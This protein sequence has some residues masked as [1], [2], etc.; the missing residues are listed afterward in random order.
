MPREVLPGAAV[1]VAVLVIAYP[2]AHT[3]EQKT[4]FFLAAILF[5][6][7]AW[8]PLIVWG[9]QARRA[10][11]RRSLQLDQLWTE[12]R[13]AR[14]RAYW[15]TATA[16][17]VAALVLDAIPHPTYDTTCLYETKPATWPLQQRVDAA[18]W[19]KE[20]LEVHADDRP[21]QAVEIRRLR[22]DLLKE[23]P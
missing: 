22:G 3:A 5:N 6:I 17:D 19:C 18:D 20:W 1:I 2:A 12:L 4:Y 16:K 21:T 9:V 13:H 11:R 8:V 14:D 7:F 10:N 15:T 23:L